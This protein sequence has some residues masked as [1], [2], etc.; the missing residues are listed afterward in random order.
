MRT[1]RGASALAE[2]MGRNPEELRDRAISETERFIR[3][4][5]IRDKAAALL[6]P[7][8]GGAFGGGGGGGPFGG[9]GGGFGGGAGFGPRFGAPG[10][11]P[12]SSSRS[13]ERNRPQAWR[14]P[15]R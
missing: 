3:D 13:P 12:G 9:G 4:R 1:G 6:G 10:K 8:A 15:I 5:A 14:G 11:R 7:A 2:A